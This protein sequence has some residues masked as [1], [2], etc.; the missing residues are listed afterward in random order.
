MM[1]TM[2]MTMYVERM[3]RTRRSTQCDALLETELKNVNATDDI[4]DDDVFCR[5]S[6]RSM[7]VV[8]G[9]RPG[10]RSVSLSLLLLMLVT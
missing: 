2:M 3:Q 7:R 4:D 5:S 10:P 8:C 6:C 9:R 1:M